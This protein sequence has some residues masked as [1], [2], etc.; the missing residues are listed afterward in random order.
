MNAENVFEIEEAKKKQTRH[1]K[2]ALRKRK[3][4][5][6]YLTFASDK[7]SIIEAMFRRENGPY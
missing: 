7:F 5:N 3:E 6:R 1:I 2:L 4:T